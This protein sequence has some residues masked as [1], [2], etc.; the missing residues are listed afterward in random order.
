VDLESDTYEEI[1][2][3]FDIDELKAKE[4][5]FERNSEWLQYCCEENAFNSLADF[6]DGKITGKAFDR[7]KQINCFAEIAANNDGTCGEKL[8]EF[9]KDHVRKN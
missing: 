2:I 9:I 6:L 4:P 8:H 7:E 3:E 1:N 5:G